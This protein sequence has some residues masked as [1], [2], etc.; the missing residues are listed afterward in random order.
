MKN[1]IAMLKDSHIMPIFLSFLK[2]A[3]GENFFT[4]NSADP[5]IPWPF[6]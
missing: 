6:P 4:T 5:F 2:F 1:E 3:L